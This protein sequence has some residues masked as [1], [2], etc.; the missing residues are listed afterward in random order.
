[1]S[2]ITA[3]GLRAV[4][5]RTPDDVWAVGGASSHQGAESTLAEHW[6]GHAWT[7]VSTPGDGGQDDQLYSVSADEENDAWAVGLGDGGVAGVDQGLAEHWDGQT[8]E[9][10]PMPATVGPLT[11]VDALSS[12]DAWAVGSAGVEDH[13]VEVVLHWDGSVWTIVDSQDQTHELEHDYSSVV[14]LSADDVWVLGSRD[15]TSAR[16]RGHWPYARHFDG[17]TWSDVPTARAVHDKLAEF[18]AAAPDGAGGLWAVGGHYTEYY[19]EQSPLIE[20]W[21]GTRW[22]V[23]PVPTLPLGNGLVGVSAGSPTTAWA[24]G[25]AKSG[26]TH[27]LVWNGTAWHG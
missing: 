22:R 1:M 15:G 18:S 7:V 3:S 24:V 27:D 4:D 9:V 19:D 26:P 16:P 23:E 25:S 20:H 14:A 17:S 13:R 6:D 21:D 12:T 2:S 8:W 5:A 11:S 10:S